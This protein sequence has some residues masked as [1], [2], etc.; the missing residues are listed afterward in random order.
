MQKE[1][2]EKVLNSQPL[3]RKEVRSVCRFVSKRFG[4]DFDGQNLYGD[5]VIKIR[6]LQKMIQ[7]CYFLKTNEELWIYGGH[8]ENFSKRIDG[9][10]SFEEKIRDLIEGR[11]EIVSNSILTFA[12]YFS[13]L[14]KNFSSINFLINA[15]IRSIDKEPY[16][17]P[18]SISE[19]KLFSLIESLI[20][21]IDSINNPNSSIFSN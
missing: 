10:S 12:C 17:N 20:E 21:I 5:Q 4:W 3:D 2:R 6:P 13:R 1:I 11:F 18:A 7:E 14:I 8:R 16:E 15:C 19:Y 9:V